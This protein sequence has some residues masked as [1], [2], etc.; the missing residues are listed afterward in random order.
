MIRPVLQAKT[1]GLFTGLL[2]GHGLLNSLATKHLAYMTKSFVFINLGTSIGAPH[3]N[4]KTEDPIKV[5][6]A[7]LVL[8]SHNCRSS[9]HYSTCRDALGALCIWQC[10]YRQSDRRMEHW[11]RI[12][13]WIAF[14]PVD[15]KSCRIHLFLD[16]A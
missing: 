7:F 11:H 8:L 5:F 16:V 1:V 13:V 6:L 15:G 12:L 3:I 9:G 14:G 10:R 4:L 2:I